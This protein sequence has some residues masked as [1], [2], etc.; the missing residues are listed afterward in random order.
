[1][2]STN[3]IESALIY[4]FV[5]MRLVQIRT[6]MDDLHRVLALASQGQFKECKRISEVLMNSRTSPAVIDRFDGFFL[7]C[8]NA[9]FRHFLTLEDALR[10]VV[11]N[12]VMDG[13]VVSHD[14]DE[15]PSVLCC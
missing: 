1:M 15:E 6:P 8:D 4:E 11:A 2:D 12:P 5:G 14:E 10:A 9:P 13:T 3:T 7:I